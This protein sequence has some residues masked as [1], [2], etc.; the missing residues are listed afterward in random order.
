MDAID[1]LGSLLGHKT[2]QSRGSGPDILKDIL[3]GGPSRGSGSQSRP[4]TSDEIA[5]Q[6][7]ELEDMLNVAHGRQTSRTSGSTR[8]SGPTINEGRRVP[9]QPQTP[10]SQAP[11]SEAG[12]RALVL[13]RAMVNAAKADG[14]ISQEEQQAILS[15]MSGSSREA[16]QFLQDEFRKPLDVREFVFSVPVGMEQ[17]VYMMSLAAINLDNAR[18]AKYLMEL[19]DGLRI[20]P[21]VREQIHQ[22]M[23]A[24]SMY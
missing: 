11:Q 5:R 9:T 20:S 17:Q 2:S 12:D 3:G 22:R 13:V 1:I 14:Q 16:V 21:E 19:A 10:K 18:E 23:G 8:T 24:P 15:R 7:K 4:P 6:S